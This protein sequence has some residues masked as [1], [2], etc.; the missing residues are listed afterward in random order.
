MKA[1]SPLRACS[2]LV[3]L[4]LMAATQVRADTFYVAV[5]D[6]GF[7]PGSLQIHPG[8]TVVWYNNDADDFPH[9]STSYLSIIN[10]NYWNIDLVSYLDAAGHTFNNIGMF[11]YHDKSGVGTGTIVVA[12][13]AIINLVESRVVA[14]QY[15]FDAT[16]LTAG[17]NYEVLCSTNLLDWTSIST[18]AASAASMTFTNSIGSG[19]ACYRLL[20]QP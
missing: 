12:A 7:S 10:V 16:G 20:Q 19:I 14:G 13:P 8:D 15:L 1:F 17:K 4:F 3:T 9:S 6:S 2:A 18:N 5:D 11:D